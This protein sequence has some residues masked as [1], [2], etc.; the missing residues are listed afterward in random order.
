MKSPDDTFITRFGLY[1]LND[2][3]IA[4]S[5]LEEL[6]AEKEVVVEMLYDEIS[7]KITCPDYELGRWYATTVATDSLALD[8]IEVKEG[9]DRKMKRYEEKSQMFE[10]A[11]ETLT[12]REKD[13][14]RVQYFSFNNQLGLSPEYFAE[15]L[16]EAQNKMCV[17]I[18]EK[19]LNDLSEAKKRHKEELRKQV[20][21]YKSHRVN[22]S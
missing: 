14:I 9:F 1:E 22:V 4:A 8:I 5:I 19:K 11:M 18:G 21:E 7:P 6:K 13:V 3:A 17:F 12:P 15:V 10:L 2:Y 20:A 16:Q